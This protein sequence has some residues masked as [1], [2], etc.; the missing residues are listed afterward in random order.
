MK[1]S[2]ISSSQFTK[3]Y[4]FEIFTLADDIKANPEKYANSLLGKVLTTLFFEPSTRTRLSFES[5]L[6]RLG[7]KL[8]TVENGLLNS[9]ANKGES[10]QDTIRIVQGYSD[11]IIM[12]HSENQASEIALEVAE[13]PIINAGDGSGEHPT[14]SLLDLYT[15]HSKKGSLDNLSIAFIGDLKFGRTVHSLVKSLSLFDNIVFYGVSSKEFELPNT[16]LE[17]LTSENISYI[18]L[19]S[20]EEIPKDIDVLYQ[21]RVQTERFKDSNSNIQYEQLIINKEKFKQF[22]GDTILMHPL[23]RN[24]EIHTD[25]DD[26]PRAIYF[27]QSRNGLYVRMALL[28]LLLN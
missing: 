10:I 2:L 24:E 17:W 1:K 23:P 12:R 14:Q 26:D 11:G 21:T 25:V 4:V 18:P 28:H 8:L 6:Q 19:R 20:I 22:S 9:S 5:A 27:E 7:A 15:I 16:Y 3:E 13:V